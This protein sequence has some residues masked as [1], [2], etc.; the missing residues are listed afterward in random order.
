M[1]LVRELLRP[2]YLKW[3]YFRL[4]PRRRPSGFTECWQRGQPGSRENA[5]VV[6]LPMS[7]WHGPRQRTQQLA[8]A[9]AGRGRRCLYVNPHLGREFPQPWLFSRSSI[10]LDVAERVTELHVHLPLEPVFHHRALRDD[11]EIRVVEAIAARLA[12]GGVVVSCF[13]LWNG[14]AQRLRES[15]GALI[16]YDCHDLLEGFGNVA[17]ELLAREREAMA[18]ADVVVFSSQPLADRWGGRGTIIRNAGDPEHF[19]LV[20]WKARPE[21]PV[22][23]YVGALNHWF[24]SDAVARAAEQRREWEFRLVGPVDSAD[25]SRLRASSNVRLVGPVNYGELPAC[26]AVFDVALIPF[27]L[28]PL[29]EAVN[30]VKLYEYLACGLPVVS[31]QLPEVVTF[32]DHLYTYGSGDSLAAA[33][34]IALR[35]D[36]QERREAR[37]A[38]VAGETWA[39]RA[40]AM[41]ALIVTAQ[42]YTAQTTPRRRHNA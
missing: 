23:G 33:I 4:W 20:P 2:W 41:E 42:Q 30:P 17:S 11:E 36:N 3:C 29:I 14:V 13:P 31:A 15:H 26:M 22:I 38:A 35:E 39:A 6:F 1:G 7:D 16:V 37:R 28:T 19:R 25:V 8:L 18:A 5:D 12:R 10:A 24:D 34:E 21:R 32:C 27:K 9:L 40:A